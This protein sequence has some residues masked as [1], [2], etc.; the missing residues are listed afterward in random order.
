MGALSALSTQVCVWV[1]CVCACVCCVC[2]Q[3]VGFVRVGGRVRGIQ[4]MQAHI[5]PGQ[6]RSVYVCL[7]ALCMRAVRVHVCAVCVRSVWGS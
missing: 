2:S 5:P 7:C 1:R 4:M 6:I 3:Y